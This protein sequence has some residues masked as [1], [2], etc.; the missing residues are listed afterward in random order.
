MSRRVLKTP[1]VL[2]L[3]GLGRREVLEKIGVPVQVELLGVGENV[4][5]HI[6]VGMSYGKQETVACLLTFLSDGTRAEGRR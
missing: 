2:E 4:Q 1:Q 3:S 6:Y 5:D